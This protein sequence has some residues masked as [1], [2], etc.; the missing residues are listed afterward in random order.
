[1][2]S[3]VYSFLAIYVF[4]AFNSLVVKTFFDPDEY[5][6]SLEVAH[7]HVFG[8]GY[9]TWEWEARIRYL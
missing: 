1:M 7:E 9:L 4:R 2:K 5:W 6:Q 8:Y 3:Y